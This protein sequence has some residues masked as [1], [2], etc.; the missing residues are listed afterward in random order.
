MHVCLHIHTHTYTHAL[1]CTGLSHTSSNSQAPRVEGAFLLEKLSKTPASFCPHS[2]RLC[3]LLK[4]TWHR[5]HVFLQEVY[6]KISGISGIW[7]L[8]S[9]LRQKEQ[10]R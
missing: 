4:V 3:D 7:E 9:A 6:L 8:S 1:A 2:Q 10:I 5:F